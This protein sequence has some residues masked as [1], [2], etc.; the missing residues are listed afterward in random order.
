MSAILRPVNSILWCSGQL[1][2]WFR[3]F[4]KC[5]NDD[6]HLSVSCWLWHPLCTKN[7]PSNNQPNKQNPQNQAKNKINNNKTKNQ[8][9]PPPKKAPNKKQPKI[10]FSVDKSLAPTD[11]KSTFFQTSF[12]TLVQENAMVATGHCRNLLISRCG[13][14]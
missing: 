4:K 3:E 11:I 5:G 8:T 13:A 1:Y 9:Q 2:S 6:S 14:L 10:F 12:Y 7:S